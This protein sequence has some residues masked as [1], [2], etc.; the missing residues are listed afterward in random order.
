MAPVPLSCATKSPPRAVPPR[1]VPASLTPTVTVV[2]SCAAVTAGA[3]PW[4]A[5]SN[6]LSAPVVFAASIAAAR[7]SALSI[8]VVSIGAGIPDPFEPPPPPQ[9]ASPS[10]SVTAAQTVVRSL[11]PAIISTPS[12]LSSRPAPPCPLSRGR[13]AHT[14]VRTARAGTPSPLPRGTHTAVLSCKAWCAVPGDD[15]ISSKTTCGSAIGVHMD[16][17][18][19]AVPCT[20]NVARFGVEGATHGAAERREAIKRFELPSPALRGGGRCAA[21]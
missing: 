5:S 20:G 2:P 12:S 1:G 14:I 9:A 17:P 7:A 8:P 21:K 13:G 18:G 11:Y 10:A 6:V 16:A 4:A 19:A 3:T 15:A